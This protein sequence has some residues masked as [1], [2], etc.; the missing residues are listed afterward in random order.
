MLQ[1]N[2][3]PRVLGNRVSDRGYFLEELPNIMKIQ[4]FLKSPPPL[5]ISS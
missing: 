1:G 4:R 2:V 3:G 5:L